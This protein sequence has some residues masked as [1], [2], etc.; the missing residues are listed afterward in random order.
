[1]SEH[2]I[3]EG[4][5]AVPTDLMTWARSFEK[6]DRIVAK[7]DTPNG[8]VSTVFLGLNHNWGDGPPLLF[9]TMVFGGTLDGDMDRYSTYEQAEAGHA[10]MCERVRL[11][12]GPE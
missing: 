8:K 2:Y 3:L 12:K 5:E 4:R 7:T 6:S 10:A 9:E 11:G 1:V